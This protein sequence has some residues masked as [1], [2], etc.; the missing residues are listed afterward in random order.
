MEI[1]IPDM[2]TLGGAAVGVPGSISAIYKIHSKFGSLPIED[3]FEPAIN[4]AKNGFVVTQKQSNSL[5]G[6]LEDLS[7]LTEKNLYI[8]K[9]IMKVTQSRI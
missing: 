5:T 8:Q 3:L 7:K 6:K 1:V 4:L 2:S 9:G